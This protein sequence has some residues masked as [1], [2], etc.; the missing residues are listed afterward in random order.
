MCG[1]ECVFVGGGGREKG[2]TEMDL[3][4]E[5]KKLLGIKR[6]RESL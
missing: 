3:L 2:G 1:C 6:K 5:R 4:L